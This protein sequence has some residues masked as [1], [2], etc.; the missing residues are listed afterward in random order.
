[1][2]QLTWSHEYG[3]NHIDVLLDHENYQYSYGYIFNRKSGQQ[4]EDMPY[5]DNFA[6]VE[7][8]SEYKIKTTTES[9]L[10]RVRYNYDQK[11]FGEASIRRDGTSRFADGDCWG[12]FWSVGASWVISKEKFMHSLDWVNYLKLRAAYGSVGNNVVLNS[13]GSQNY[14]PAYGLYDFGWPLNDNVV[15]LQPCC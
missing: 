14:Y 8:L 5:M 9:Y 13:N 2:Q 12:T 3:L 1:M 7:S 10:G 4:L 6:D 15:I 11:Y